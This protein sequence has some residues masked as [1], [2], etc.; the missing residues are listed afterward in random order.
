MIGGEIMEAKAKKKKVSFKKVLLISAITLVSLFIAYCI[1]WVCLY[2]FSW[3]KHIG[4]A[5]P[6]T[7]ESDDLGFHGYCIDDGDDSYEFFIP[8]FPE[9][10]LY[11]IM[12]SAT[13]IVD[14]N[15]PYSGANPKGFDVQFGMICYRNII[16]NTFDECFFT[17]VPYKNMGN[18]KKDETYEFKT[19]E[20]GELDENDEYLTDEGRYLYEKYKDE[21]KNIMKK[22][23]EFFNF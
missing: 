3:K 7:D 12:G 6:E 8:K 22:S 11:Y 4:N 21:V 1:L 19:K 23:E 14:I 20:N 10:R 13:E 2:N 5:V 9:I 17:I 16:T 15:D 18:C